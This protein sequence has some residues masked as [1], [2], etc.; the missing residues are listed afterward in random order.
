MLSGTINVRTITATALAAG[1]LAATPLMAAG[2]TPA[3]GIEGKNTKVCSSC[4]KVEASTYRG[5]FEN[6]AMKT[7]SL[8]IRV[9]EK[10]EIIKFD[11]AAIK[12]SNPDV[13][14]A[15]VEKQLRGIKKNHEV[16]VV[17]EM[18]NGVPYAKEI[19][20]KPP[21]KVD[22]AKLIKLEEVQKLVAL[23]P[24]KGNFTLI[25]SRPLPRYQDGFIPGA[26]NLPFPAFDKN[27]DKL[28]A[29]K[30]RLIVFYCAGITCTMSPKSM[31][32]A[33]KLGYKNAKVFREGM[34]GWL[35]KKPG[36]MTVK[37]IKEAW[38]DKQVPFVL[39]DARA[40]KDAEKAFIKGAVTFANADEKAI[41]TLPKKT[42]KAP[43][44]VY[45]ADGKGN[46]Q[47]V[48]QGIVTAGY[49]P[50]LVVDGGLAAWKK[51]GL[52]VE[53][54]TLSTKIAYTPKPKTGEIS[55]D[56][57]KKLIAAIPSDTII[58]DVRAPDEVKEGSI[59]GMVNI[60]N[61]EIDK[62]LDKLPKDKKIVTYCNSGT[63]A[64]MAYHILKGKGYTNVFFLNAK[65][66]VDE[67]KVEISR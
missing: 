50:V 61:E 4:H 5:Y 41:K 9:D 30:N 34:P 15:N 49:A 46:A 65:V 11:K 27:L 32:K 43:I 25:D 31:E 35:Q 16:K 19:V 40:Q 54:G 18:K 64:E 17:L 56:N 52:P 12:V 38:L 28:P 33:E 58:V 14:D 23:G 62:N 22:E 36:T 63:M 37:F 45:D 67:G 39:L 13:K 53:K 8:Q 3:G 21:I 10:S 29:D 60:P 57:F 66:E 59:P 7:T 24:E 51:A 48:A 2:P 1:I 26:I 6:V 47:A 55:I 42:M 44:F 20:A